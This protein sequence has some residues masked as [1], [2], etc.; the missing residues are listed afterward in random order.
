M[1]MIKSAVWPGPLG[2]LGKLRAEVTE[3][4]GLAAVRPAAEPSSDTDNVCGEFPHAAGGWGEGSPFASQ[5]TPWLE[6]HFT[7]KTVRSARI[8]ALVSARFNACE[9]LVGAL[10]QANGPG[11]PSSVGERADR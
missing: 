3:R 7:A 1:P 9:D 5:I 2:E 11:G 6:A 8:I 10:V 4:P